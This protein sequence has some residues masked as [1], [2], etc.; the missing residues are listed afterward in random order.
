[1]AKKATYQVGDDVR[2]PFGRG[3]AK[4]SVVSINKGIVRVLTQNGKAVNRN[5]KNL[6]KVIPVPSVS[7]PCLVW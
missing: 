2:I 1:M 7:A 6:K 4:G 3:Y 5:V